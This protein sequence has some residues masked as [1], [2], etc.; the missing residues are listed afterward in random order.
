MT[1]KR[2]RWIAV[3]GLLLFWAGAGFAHL[4]GSAE[5]RWPVTTAT[6]LHSALVEERS[7]ECDDLPRGCSVYRP[8]VRYRYEVEGRTYEG[9]RLSSSS[10]AYT[11]DEARARRWIAPFAVGARV[12]VHVDSGNPNNS[13]LAPGM[14]PVLLGALVIGGLIWG[15]LWWLAGALLD[16]RA[17]GEVELS[18]A[19]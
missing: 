10:S 6:I 5:Q 2:A 7:M 17:R 3:V 14:S 4:K 9:T 8:E 13:V 1:R 11:G 12:P 15:G 18:R 16:R 19:A